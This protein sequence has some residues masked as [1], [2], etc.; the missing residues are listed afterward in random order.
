MKYFPP[1]FSSDIWLIYMKGGQVMEGS[2][3][4]YVELKRQN[5]I[6]LTYSWLKIQTPFF[7][8]VTGDNR[9]GPQQLI[10]LAQIN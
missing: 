1:L 5:I 6:K 4:I 8:M 2:I 9:K 3:K 7:S 10:L